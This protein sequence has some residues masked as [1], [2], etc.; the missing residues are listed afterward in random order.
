MKY[1]KENLLDILLIIGF[2]I[3]IMFGM[4]MYKNKDKIYFNTEIQKNV[5]TVK[6]KGIDLLE[7]TNEMMMND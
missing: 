2:C 6:D 3:A 7:L 4:N 5:D 1:I